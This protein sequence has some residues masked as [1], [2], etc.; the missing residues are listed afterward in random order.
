MF[1]VDAFFNPGYGLFDSGDI[2][3]G[4]TPELELGDNL[5]LYTVS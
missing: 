1:V 3:E 5:V 4:G 2:A